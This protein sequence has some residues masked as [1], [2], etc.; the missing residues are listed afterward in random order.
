MQLLYWKSRNLHTT[1]TLSPSS[2]STR[3]HAENAHTHGVVFCKGWAFLTQSSSRCITTGT[4]S[5]TDKIFSLKN[6]SEIELILLSHVLWTPFESIIISLATNAAY[7]FTPFRTKLVSGQWLSLVKVKIWCRNLTWDFEL[8]PKSPTFLIMATRIG[9]S[10]ASL[11][12][13]N[14][15]LR[16]WIMR[17]YCKQTGWVWV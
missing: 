5:Q 13:G 8:L 7:A 10:R 17:H 4:L 2:S 6:L 9:V 11:W 3:T 12:D 16:W 14:S 1:C 15:I